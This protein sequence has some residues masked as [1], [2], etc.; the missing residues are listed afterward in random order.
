MKRIT[1]HGQYLYLLFTA[2]TYKKNLTAFFRHILTKHFYFQHFCEAPF[3][4]LKVEII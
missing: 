2:K 4:A 1:Q 3:Y